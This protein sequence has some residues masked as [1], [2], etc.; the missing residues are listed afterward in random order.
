MFNPVSYANSSACYDRLLRPL[1]RA[2]ASAYDC[3]RRAPV[4]STL[5]SSFA[6]VASICLADLPL[7]SSASAIS[8]DVAR[9]CSTLANK[10]YPPRV[11]GNPAAGRANGTA[12]DFRAY[13]SKCVANGGS[14]PTPEQ[15]NNKPDQGSGGSGSVGQPPEAPKGQ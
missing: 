5:K 9:Q 14:M 2:N 1:Q 13:F 3:P 11:P 12:Q 6:L 7:M 4:A 8:V 10:T 15:H